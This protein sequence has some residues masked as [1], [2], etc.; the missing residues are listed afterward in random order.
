MAGIPKVPGL[1]GLGIDAVDVDR[2]R[3]VLNRRPGVADRVFTE[4]ELADAGVG[5]LREERLAARFAAKEALMKALGVGIGGFA[6][7]DVEVR[8]EK[9]GPHRGAPSLTLSSRAA[10]LAD[11]N[12]VTRSHVSLTH[13]SSL[14]MAVVALEVST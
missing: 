9:T 6:F 14:A 4:A 12:G 10:E 2:F 3:S 11:R 1:A 7:R 13:T 5:R 8:R